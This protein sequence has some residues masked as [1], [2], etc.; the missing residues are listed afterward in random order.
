[1]R[2]A[3]QCLAQEES[4]LPTTTRSALAINGKAT[5]IQLSLSSRCVGGTLGVVGRSPRAKFCGIRPLESPSA[6]RREQL[7]PLTAQA[8]TRESSSR[9]FV[10]QRSPPNPRMLLIIVLY[11]WFGRRIRNCVQAQTTCGHYFPQATIAR[12]APEIRWYR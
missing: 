1:M 9:R 7:V 2:T 10:C 8:E 3:G 4:L 11:E 5:A 12:A 6:R